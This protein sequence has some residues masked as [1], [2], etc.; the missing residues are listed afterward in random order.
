MAYRTLQEIFD[1][2]AVH[3]LTQKEKAFLRSDYRSGCAYR[4]GELKCAIGALIPDDKYGPYMEGNSVLTDII[5]QAA[6]I[7]ED[8]AA[9]ASRLQIIHDDC[10]PY[11]WYREL[12]DLAVQHGI[13]RDC[14]KPFQE[15]L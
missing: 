4:A 5:R 1:I 6:N 8:D 9:F 2:C 14:L 7:S 13:N 15:T 12:Q 11:H 3:L 10:E